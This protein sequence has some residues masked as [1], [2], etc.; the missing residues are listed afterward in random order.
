MIMYDDIVTQFT[1]SY[2]LR[3]FK[4]ISYVWGK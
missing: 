2:D 3:W 4:I 1:I